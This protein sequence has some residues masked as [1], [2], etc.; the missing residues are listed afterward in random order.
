[1]HVWD[2]VSVPRA[3]PVL[4]ADYTMTRNDTPCALQSSRPRLPPGG[5]GPQ[6]DRVTPSR[7][8]VCTDNLYIR[9]PHAGMLRVRLDT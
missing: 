6:D 7:P 4:A 2:L 1:M 9:L 5:G 3:G 8:S